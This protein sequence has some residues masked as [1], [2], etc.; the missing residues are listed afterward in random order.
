MDQNQESSQL[1]QIIGR[2]IDKY[3]S[4]FAFGS[5]LIIGLS[6]FFVPLFVWLLII[7]FSAILYFIGLYVL[8]FTLQRTIPQDIIDTGLQHDRV[9]ELIEKLRT[10]ELKAETKEFDDAMRHAGLEPLAVPKEFG[11]I[12]G[13]RGDDELYEWIDGT[14]GIDGPLERYFFVKA[15]PSNDF[16]HLLRDCDLKQSHL[17]HQQCVYETRRQPKNDQHDDS[18]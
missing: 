18:N 14:L 13:K 15:L 9:V 7:G 5:L 8:A 10:G 4:T 2:L 17:I 12:F 3:R 16:G 11:P 1:D 6:F